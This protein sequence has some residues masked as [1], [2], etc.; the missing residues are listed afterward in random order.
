LEFGTIRDRAGHLLGIDA[1]AS[2][3]GQ[4]VPLQGKILVELRYPRVTDQHG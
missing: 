3:P 2:G 1:L 4:R